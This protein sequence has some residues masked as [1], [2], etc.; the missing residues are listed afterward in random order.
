MKTIEEVK[1]FLL[2]K[3][4]RLLDVLDDRHEENLE[5]DPDADY[6]S[7]HNL[8]LDKDGM[9]Y[10]FGNADD[11]YNDGFHNGSYDGEMD[12]INQL[13]GMIDAGGELS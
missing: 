8:G 13:L 4:Q 12:L 7:F 10:S 3:K 2:T 9:P 5:I 11:V 1:Q 6:P